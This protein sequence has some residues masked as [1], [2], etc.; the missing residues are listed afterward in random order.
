VT[1]S[2]STS[3][4]RQRLVAA[5]LFAFATDPLL[6]QSQLPT[7]VTDPARQA[8]RRAGEIEAISREAEDQRLLRPEREVTY[9]DVLANPDN[10][11]LNFAYAQVQI[12]RG[13]LK[14]AAATLER[15][16]LI[17]QDLPRV[18]LLYAIV[19]FRLDN[20]DEAERELHLTVI[21]SSCG[22]GGSARV[23]L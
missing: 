13:D 16:L 1:R 15:I 14:N 8:T 12:A 21:W 2:S 20:L 5:L 4:W 7:D 10:I 23:T 9:E 19:L 3:V 11:D 22:Y 18:R 6:A 17:E